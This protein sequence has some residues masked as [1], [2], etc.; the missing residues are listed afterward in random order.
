MRKLHLTQ[1]GLAER[2]GVSSATVSRWM[3][4]THEPTGES[5]VAL[6]NLAGPPDDVYFWEQAGIN[7][8]RFP[9]S[10]SRVLTS[11]LKV[12]LD[13]FQFISGRQLSRS[14]LVGKGNAVAIPLLNM[15]AY[16]DM[17]PP[18]ENVRLS[19]ARIEE[20][21]TVPLAWCTHPEAMICIHMT[22]DSMIPVI[23]PNTIIAVDTEMTDRKTVEN[24]IVLASHR[25]LGFKVALFERLP[26]TDILLPAN[27]K[28]PPIDIT[29]DRKW[30]I[31]GQVLWWLTKAPRD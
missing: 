14:T 11:S 30:K 6:G 3:K 17:V 26:S 13:N 21:L 9:G 22:G 2:L 7:T 4:G 29:H 15:T 28:Y 25:N 23:G 24:K 8:A 1:A 16:G 31:F 12:K 18:E 5:Y 20:V 10:S 27:H 19:D